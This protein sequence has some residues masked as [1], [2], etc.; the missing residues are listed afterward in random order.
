MVLQALNEAGGIQYLVNVAHKDPKTFCSLLGRVLP[1][2]LTGANE[3][4]VQIVA[5]WLPPQ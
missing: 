3:G 1:L 4:P 2:Q 5:R